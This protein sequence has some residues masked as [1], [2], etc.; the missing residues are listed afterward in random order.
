[1]VLTSVCSLQPKSQLD[2]TD[3][4]AV[5]QLTK[6]LLHHD[7]GLKIDL[8]DNRLCPPVSRGGRSSS[9]PHAVL[10]GSILTCERQVPNRHNYIL[11]LKDLLDSTSYNEPGARLSGLDIGTGA[12]CIYPLLACAQRPWSLIAT[13]IDPANVES[14][15]RNVTLNNMQDRIKVHLSRSNGPMVPLAELGLPRLDFVMTNPP[16]YA[17]EDEMLKLATKK[18]RPP[19]SACTGAPVEMVCEGGEVAFVGRIL[20]ESLVLRDRV[21]WYTAM[22][23]LVSSLEVMVDR[24]REQAIDNYAVTEFIQGNKTRRWAIAWSFA[25]MKPAQTICRGMKATAWRKVLP[26]IVEVEILTFP[27]SEGVGKIGDVLAELVGGLDLISWAWDK[28]LL[29]GTGRARENV[30]SRSWRRKRKREELEDETSEKDTSTALKA[31]ES[32][33]CVFGFCLSILVNKTEAVV[34]CRW[35]EGHDEAIFTSFCGFVKTRLQNHI[36]QKNKPEGNK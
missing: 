7:F 21:Q 24:L 30:W 5:K 20:E 18:S 26:A 31:R 36:P 14:A 27:I 25:P 34:G 16:F 28:E 32:E 17:S 12:S 3:P 33:I 9:W 22:F 13:D 10:C 19:H 2:F 4:A 15:R 29:R 8:P 23:G 6:T 1:M 35:R 11:W